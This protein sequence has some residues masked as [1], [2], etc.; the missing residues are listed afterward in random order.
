LK[1]F[2]IKVSGIFYVLITLVKIELFP[3][4]FFFLTLS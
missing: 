4:I 1:P 2:Y 3:M